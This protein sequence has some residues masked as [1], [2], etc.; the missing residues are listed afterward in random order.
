[1]VF[2]TDFFMPCAGVSQKMGKK[3]D[4]VCSLRTSLSCYKTGISRRGQAP[5]W[6]GL[7]SVCSSLRRSLN[8]VCVSLSKST[9][10]LILPC[11]FSVSSVILSMFFLF[12]SA[13]NC[14]SLIL[15]SAFTDALWVS[16]ERTWA[17][18]IKREKSK[19]F[20]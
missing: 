1:M 6:S 12:S 20:L 5:L 17:V 8:R 15:L 16:A 2:I 9:H 19:G 13:V 3:S 4:R 14:I 11:S 7:L 10:V 18:A